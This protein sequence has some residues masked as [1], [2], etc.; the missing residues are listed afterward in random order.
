MFCDSAEDSWT[1]LER[2]SSVAARSLSVC[3]A[4]AVWDSPS[5]RKQIL[6]VVTSWHLGISYLQQEE[7]FA[8][9]LCSSVAESD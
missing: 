8:D 6:P 5:G 7:H 3:A 1:L 9:S 2:S 4:R